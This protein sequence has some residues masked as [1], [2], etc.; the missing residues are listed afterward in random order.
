MI[1]D[2]DEERKKSQAGITR[3]GLLP[4]G[5]FFSLNEK[6]RRPAREEERAENRDD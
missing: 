6:I 4:R 1:T 3:G 2:I 5:R